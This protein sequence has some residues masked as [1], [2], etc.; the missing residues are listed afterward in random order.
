VTLRIYDVAGREVAR[1]AHKGVEGPNTARW[2]GQLAN[3]AR[4]LPGVYFYALDGVDFA[5][6]AKRSS[7]LILLSGGEGSSR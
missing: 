1:V 6:G 4:A 5:P 2:D 7:K 3:G